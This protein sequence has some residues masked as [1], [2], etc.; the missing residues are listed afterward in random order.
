MSDKKNFDVYRYRFSNGPASYFY[1]TMDEMLKETFKADMI[2]DHAFF[3]GLS[4]SDA[5]GDD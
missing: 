1:D 3:V 5:V 2:A 4:K